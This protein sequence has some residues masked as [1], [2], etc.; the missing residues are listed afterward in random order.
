[1]TPRSLSSAISIA[2][3]SSHCLPSASTHHLSLRLRLQLFLILFNPQCGQE[4]HER[5]KFPAPDSPGVRRCGSIPTSAA[6]E[7]EDRPDSGDYSFVSQL[8][9]FDLTTSSALLHFSSPHFHGSAK[10]FLPIAPLI[11]TYSCVTHHVVEFLHVVINTIQYIQFFLYHS[12]NMTC[13]ALAS[14]PCPH[15]W[16]LTGMAQA[17]RHPEP[18]ARSYL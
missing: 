13:F 4:L 8:S 1:M 6:N 2:I 10:C 9:L 18:H 17:H 12:S 7:N 15:V 14:T 16:E 11:D 3:F 5:S